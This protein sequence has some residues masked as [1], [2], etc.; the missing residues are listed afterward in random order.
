MACRNRLVRRAGEAEHAGLVLA[1]CLEEERNGGGERG[2]TAKQEVLGAAIKAVGR[3]G[4]IYR[5]AYD[6]RVRD[7]TAA[8]AE[9][10]EVAVAWRLAIGLGNESV[11]E[12]GTTLHRTYGTPVIPG[13]ALKG[14][15]A[16]Y[17]D[18]VWGAVDAR[19]KEGGEFHR[20]MFGVTLDAG[21]ITFHDAWILP[22]C[23]GAGL[24]TDTMT[25]H[26]GD[27]YMGKDDQHPPSDF[28]DPV[29]VAFLAVT[30]TF[31]A[32]VTCDGEGAEAEKWAVRALELLKTALRE[33]GV[34]GKTNSGYGRMG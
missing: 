1:Y 5:M 31:H 12:T 28:D 10:A 13:T 20:E 2:P 26:H 4:A 14:L 18:S 9:T 16:H 33:W 23:L 8:G 30:G 6:R 24:V 11:V 25:P 29:P 3:S 17:C 27:Y 21:H 22:A 15:A 7:L 19:Y 34:G 32:A